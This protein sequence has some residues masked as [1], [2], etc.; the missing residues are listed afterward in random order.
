MGPGVCEALGLITRITQTGHG[1]HTCIPNTWEVVVAGLEVQNRP[2][3]HSELKAR[4]AGVS[5]L[6]RCLSYKCEH[7]SFVSSIHMK[8]LSTAAYV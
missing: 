6:V 1:A 4:A 8:M 5:L 7:L 2:Q 3:L